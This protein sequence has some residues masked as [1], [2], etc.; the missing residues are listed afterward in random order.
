VITCTNDSLLAQRLTPE[1]IAQIHDI[2]RQCRCRPGMLSGMIGTCD[3][4]SHLVATL[5]NAEFVSGR[6][7]EA[8]GHSDYHCWVKLAD[9]TILDATADQF[10]N[11]PI[12]VIEPG[13]DQYNAYVSENVT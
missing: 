13:T 2:R 9:G 12:C 3:R 1:Q 7:I 6:L 5:I 11:D 10:S 4:V 8:D